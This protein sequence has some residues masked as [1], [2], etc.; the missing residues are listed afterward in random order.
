MKRYG[1]DSLTIGGVTVKLTDDEVKY[2]PVH[3]PKETMSGHT[4]I[5]GVSYKATLPGRME[6][7]MFMTEGWTLA[8][9][10]NIAADIVAHTMDG[11]VLSLAAAEFIEEQN[12]TINDGKVTCIFESA[13]SNEGGI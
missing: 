10:R 1:V 2:R 5:A 13:T 11:Q 12:L 8:Q 4:G 6:F 9:L 3:R 7:S